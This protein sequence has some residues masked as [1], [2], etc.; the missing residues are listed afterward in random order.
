MILQYKELIFIPQSFTK[1][2][3]HYTIIRNSGYKEQV[4]MVPMS[5][6]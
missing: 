6:L 3:V 1:D 4:L 5:S 2:L